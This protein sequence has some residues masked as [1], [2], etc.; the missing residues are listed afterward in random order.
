MKFSEDEIRDLIKQALADV[1]AGLPAENVLEAPEERF[2]QVQQALKELFTENYREFIEQVTLVA[3]K[4]AT[5]K[6]D[7]PNGNNIFLKWLGEAFEIQVEGKRYKMDYHEQF[8]QALNHITELF[9][10]GT[11]KQEGSFDEFGEEGEAGSPGSGGDFPGEPTGDFS[12]IPD[13]GGE[14]FGGEEP[15][16][17]E[18]DFT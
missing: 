8:M 11:P 4:P 9:K 17:E 2:E 18:P 10:Y 5:F 1:D 12:D 13:E 15:A 3:P 16:G 6:V 14:D 7:L